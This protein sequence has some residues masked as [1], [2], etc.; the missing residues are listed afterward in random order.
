MARKPK[1]GKSGPTEVVAT[2]LLMPPDELI[3][4]L[5]KAKRN[6]RK[7]QRDIGQ[8]FSDKFGKA[9]EEKH[10]DRRAAN[11]SFNLDSLSDEQLHVTY[12]HLLRYMDD[13][14]I[15]ERATAQNE[16]FEDKETGAGAHLNGKGDDEG[17]D[18]GNVT[19]LSAAA[20]RVAE[21]AGTDG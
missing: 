19:R 16:M 2:T 12:F 5:S 15:P 9:Q 7:Q 4:T 13:L 6:A 21:R 20:R 11:I 18:E 10:V 17:D 1:K 8:V 14:G 3:R